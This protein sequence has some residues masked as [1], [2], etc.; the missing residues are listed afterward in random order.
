MSDALDLLRERSHSYLL[1]ARLGAELTFQAADASIEELERA[2]ALTRSLFSRLNV[3]LKLALDAGDLDRFAETE[4]EWSGMFQDLWVYDDPRLQT[5]QQ[6]ALAPLLRQRDVYR[7]GLVMWCAHRLL[8]DERA[9][10][11]ETAWGNGLQVLLSRFESLSH[12]I[13]TYDA[14]VQHDRS[15]GSWTSW[16]LEGT[17]SGTAHV[18]PT[19]SK[20]LFGALVLGT[21]LSASNDQAP[22]EPRQWMARDREDY[23]KVLDE[24]LDTS[25][26]WAWL[27]PGVIESSRD[28]WTHGVGIVRRLLAEARAE[29]IDRGKAELRQAIVDL[30][31]VATFRELLR[32]AVESNRVVRDVF[33]QQ[34]ALEQVSSQPAGQEPSSSRYW[35]PKSAFLTSAPARGTEFLARDIARDVTVDGPALV[36]VIARSEPNIEEIDE[37]SVLEVVRTA[38]VD[39]RTAAYRPS[40]LLL[41]LA[42]KLKERLG[43]PLARGQSPDHPLIPSLH[44]RRFV[45]LI[46]DV[47]VIDLPRV[48]DDRFYLVDLRSAAR[49]VE[50]PSAENL[51]FGLSVDSFDLDAAERLVRDEGSALPTGQTA[52][53][54]VDVIQE[55]VR[56]T[57]TPRWKLVREDGDAVREFVVPLGLRRT[58]Q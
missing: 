52:E 35:L 51:A 41:P 9:N 7:L 5:P 57:V 23:E 48:P 11:A 54:T 29:T 12:V 4:R 25:E 21:A 32:A 38:I 44:R 39:L 42:W 28:A 16:F 22:L 24:L 15:G 20:L 49:F 27:V 19:D 17:A 18:I 6:R 33:A 10:P 50:W 26:K 3:I 37:S 2:V 14:A 58:S 56:I 40:L 55:R 53:A 43:L 31:R 36:E 45:G 13:D 30:D 8:V 47:P 1:D 34:G 46:D